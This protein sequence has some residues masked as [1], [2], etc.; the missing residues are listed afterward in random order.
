MSHRARIRLLHAPIPRCEGPSVRNNKLRRLVRSNVQFCKI[1]S[2]GQVGKVIA[3]NGTSATVQ[4]F[5]SPDECI[6][7]EVSAGALQPYEP[8]LHSRCYVRR[9]GGEWFAGRTGI[10]V[11]NGIEVLS[12]AGREY[13]EAER[14]FIRSSGLSSHAGPAEAERAH[15]GHS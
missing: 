5:K 11:D 12:E 3:A 2:T 13:F 10:A 4:L 9:S 6:V 1:V 14:V 8:P 7:A 15:A